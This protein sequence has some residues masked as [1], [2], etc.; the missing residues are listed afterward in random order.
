M[1][2]PIQQAIPMSARSTRPSV[3]RLSTVLVAAALAV[4]VGAHGPPL[5]K[6]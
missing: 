6:R 1:F 3:L 4:V 5:R 2:E